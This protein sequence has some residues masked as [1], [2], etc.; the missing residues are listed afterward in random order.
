MRKKASR[1]D[2]QTDR[3]LDGQ[4]DRQTNRKQYPLFTGDKKY[5]PFPAA[6]LKALTRRTTASIKVSI[7][8]ILGIKHDRLRNAKLVTTTHC[9]FT[10]R[11]TC[12]WH[13]SRRLLPSFIS[14]PARR[15]VYLST[16]SNKCSKKF[17]NSIVGSSYFYTN[18]IGIRFRTLYELWFHTQWTAKYASWIYGVWNRER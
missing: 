18:L 7:H 12:M 16:W 17:S 4:T 3:R 13:I 8:Q 5:V 10:W 15:C 9:G 14:P 1:T 2:G 6:P 11:C